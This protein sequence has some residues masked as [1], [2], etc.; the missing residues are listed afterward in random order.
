MSAVVLSAQTPIQFR[1]TADTVDVYA[2][3]KL[4]GGTIARDL[5]KEAFE[6]Y[7]DGKLREITI[8]SKS[9]QPLSVALV[10][11]HSGSTAPQFDDVMGASQEFLGHLLLGDR[12]SIS[13]LVWDCHPFSGDMRSL[14]TILKMRLPPD[15]GSPI[16]AGT[17]RAM[18]SFATEGG[19]RIILLLSDG[20]DNQAMAPA[21]PSMASIAPPMELVNMSPCV[22]NGQMEYR[23]A[24]DV[25]KRAEREAIMVYT[26]SVGDGTGEL[27]TI[28]KQTGASYQKLSDYNE[29]KGAFRSIADELHLQY[30]LG[31]SPSFTDGKMHKIEVK[32]KRPGVTVQARKGYVATVK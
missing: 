21:L 31:F 1:S 5:D 3:V 12:A 2:T 20:Q 29:L 8:F 32:V 28:A 30:M 24:A 4:K 17:D 19:R 16:W 27:T 25:I 7:E 6:L 15:Y 10:L 11:D 9:I 14:M 26:V 23:T 22:F 18:S 13:S